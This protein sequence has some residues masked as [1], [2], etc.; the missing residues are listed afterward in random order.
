MHVQNM[1][2]QQ[3]HQFHCDQCGT[4]FQSVQWSARLGS[5]SRRDHPS[6]TL[7]DKSQAR[8][9]H[10]RLSKEEAAHFR[11]DSP[12]DHKYWPE[13][14]WKEPKVCTIYNRH[15]RSWLHSELFRGELHRLHLKA[16]Q[17]HTIHTAFIYEER[18]EE[19]KIL[20]QPKCTCLVWK[21]QDLANTW[22]SNFCR[23][24]IPDFSHIIQSYFLIV[25]W[26]LEEIWTQS[27]GWNLVLGQRGL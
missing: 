8:Y 11:T 12:T 19:I 10:H 4:K 18:L 13:K 6:R 1:A 14:Q 25:D 26:L 21:L 24:A 3:S 15:N 20:E 9:C 16:K 5:H 2:T 17:F 23:S 22:W 7:H 27:S